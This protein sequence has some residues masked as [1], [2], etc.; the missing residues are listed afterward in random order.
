MEKFE[1]GSDAAE[2]STA[3]ETSKVVGLH[4]SKSRRHTD[5]AGHVLKTRWWQHPPIIRHI[6]EK[7]CGKPIDGFS[8]GLTMRARS[9]LDRRLPLSRG[10]SVGCGNGTKE[11]KLLREGLVQVFDL[12]ELADTRIAT[13]REL[14]EKQRLSQ[15]AHFIQGDAFRLANEPGQYDLVHWNNSLHHMLDVEAAVQW[16]WDVLKPG[17]LFYMDD[18]VA[19]DRFQWSPKMLLVA[20][21][22]RQSLPDR[23]LINPYKPNTMLGRVLKR[24]D[25]AKLRQSDPSEAADSSRILSCVKRRFPSA[26]ITLTGGVIYHLSLSDVL[27]NFTEDDRPLLDRLLV[28]DDLC[29]AAGETHYATALALKA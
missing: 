1:S 26:E 20:T 29:T 4:W 18:F 2:N 21:A 16:S 27:A 11:M 24:P 7:V 19:P 14:A 5:S 22:V 23:F 25:P 13:G 28:V 6:N 3:A 12:Y 17:G 15:S 10:I 9:L 8:A